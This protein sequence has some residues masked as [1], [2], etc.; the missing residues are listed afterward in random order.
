M[1][2]STLENDIG[3]LDSETRLLPQKARQMTPWRYAQGY[4]PVAIP[5]AAS[6]PA[7]DR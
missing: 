7:R 2:R 3:G 5:Q 1:M 6:I 4:R